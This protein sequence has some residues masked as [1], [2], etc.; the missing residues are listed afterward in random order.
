M[1]K[2]VKKE[3]D[4]S[5]VLDM[6]T[7]RKNKDSFV[8]TATEK[9]CLELASFYELPKIKKLS[10][11]F[12]IFLNKDNVVEL[13]GILE[14]DVVE[15][16]VVSSEEFSEHISAPI[17]LLFSDDEAFVKQQENVVDFSLED[18]LVEF[19]KN[20]R[21]YFYEIVREQLGLILDPF[22]KKTKEPFIYYEEK[23]EDSRENPFAMLKHL[24]K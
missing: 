2:S 3:K 17:N 5:F 18:E 24:T 14:T 11:L 20:G 4:I 1:E 21:I 10:F 22:P 9:Q 15:V 19:A 13:K 6:R 23:P 16:C 7:V 12:D 8:L